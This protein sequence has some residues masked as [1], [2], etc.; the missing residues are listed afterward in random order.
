MNWTRI[1]QQIRQPT[2]RWDLLLVAIATLS[3]S[4]EIFF[5]ANGAST[6]DW[7]DWLFWAK[8]NYEQMIASRDLF[9]LVI[10]PVQGLFGLSYPLNPFFN[11]LWLIAVLVDDSILAHRITTA[12]VFVLMA[13]ISICLLSSHVKN[14]WLRL[15][16]LFFILNVFFDHFLPLS[17]YI[18]PNTTFSYF[19]LMPPQ[20][21]LLVEA[22]AVFYFATRQS[23]PIF[24]VIAITLISVIALISD[25]FY[26]F[27]YFT[28]VILVLSIYYLIN[29]ATRWKECLAYILIGTFLFIIGLFEFP[30]L[31]KD[32]IARSV[33]NE[34]LFHSIKTVKTSSFTFQ[35]PQ[36]IAYTLPLSI[37][38]AYLWFKKK[39]S[40]ALSILCAEVLFV[41]AGIVYLSV[42]NNF[43]FIP[44]LHAFEISLIALYFIFGAK[45]IEIFLSN[46]QVARPF[47]TLT[48]PILLFVSISFVAIKLGAAFE[49]EDRAREVVDSYSNSTRVLKNVAEGK[50]NQ[51]SIG[52]ALGTQK[53]AFNENN[54]L[55]GRFGVKNRTF[56]QNNEGDFFYNRYGHTTSLISYWLNDQPTLEENN[57]MTNPFYVY[58]FRRLFM[59]PDDYYGTNGNIFTRPRKHLYPMLGVEYLF[60]DDG[61]LSDQVT[62]LILNEERFFLHRNSNFNSGQFSPSEINY[63][64]NAEQAIKHLDDSSFDPTRTALVHEQ[65]EQLMSQYRLVSSQY[66]GISYEKNGIVFEGH[67]TGISLNVLPVIF[68]NCLV[69]E[70]GHKLV[71]VNLLLTGIIF[72]EN[73]TTKLSFKGPPFDNSCLSRDIDDIETFKLTAQAFPYPNHY[74]HTDK[75]LLRDY[76][77]GVIAAAGLYDSMRSLGWDIDNWE[78]HRE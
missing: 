62:K 28:P 52:F 34:S 37:G 5:Q 64:N 18:F 36:N 65:E 42:P 13:M 55:P 44:P 20:N 32:S 69:S 27:L 59:Q 76:V 54:G 15:L 67:S 74:D 38:L 50:T 71:R 40:L 75:S 77:I 17:A 68:S 10:S 23:S 25:P 3:I 7:N 56:T 31:L 72:E 47:G 14:P 51:G 30:F 57:H 60:S 48:G 6:L 19:R 22:L 41:L 46:L 35:S 12:I 29:I 73:I 45:S 78:S 4:V 33:F 43:N 58:F 49:A 21:I 70:D 9:S 53:S 16:V 61:T 11:P 24:N 1:S 63:V 2:K 39:D 26:F 8:Q 66:G